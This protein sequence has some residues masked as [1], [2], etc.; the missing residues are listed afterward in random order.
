[1]STIVQE[2]PNI[3]F[4][5]GWLAELAIT[6]NL[7]DMDMNN[8]EKYLKLKVE[9]NKNPNMSI[10]DQFVLRLVQDF[11]NGLSQPFLAKNGQQLKKIIDDANICKY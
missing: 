4:F 2:Y 9:I 1:M 7:S 3:P 6:D 11:L 10:D 8:Y 5:Y